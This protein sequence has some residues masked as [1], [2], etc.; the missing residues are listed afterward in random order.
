MRSGGGERPVLLLY[1]LISSAMFPFYIAR[2]KLKMDR[3][4]S[5]MKHISKYKKGYWGASKF[6]A[7]LPPL[8]TPNS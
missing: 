6:C 5:H 2:R 8:L 3:V 7:P 1:Q 4:M